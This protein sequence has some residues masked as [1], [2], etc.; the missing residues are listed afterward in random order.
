[1]SLGPKIA[2]SQEAHYYYGNTQRKSLKILFS[3]TTG[4][5]AQIFGV[6]QC[7]EGLYQSCS[8]SVPGVTNGPTLGVT[9]FLQ[10]YIEKMF[11][12]FS[13]TKGPTAQIFGLEHHLDVLYQLCS[14][15]DTEIKNGQAPRGHFIPINTSI[16]LIIGDGS[17]QSV[18]PSWASCFSYFSEKTRLEISCES[19]AQP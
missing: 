5:R 19:S 17:Q 11:K 8:D 12:I 9:L 1:M 7:L 3:E 6:E 13:E 14:N 10:K 16:I 4:P 15:N 18:G 2:P